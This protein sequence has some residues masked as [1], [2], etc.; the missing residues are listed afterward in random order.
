MISVIVTLVH[1]TI[2]SHVGY[3]NSFVVPLTV[4]LPS[5]CLILV[6]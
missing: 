6:W 2:I 5:Y 4:L 3:C 1:T